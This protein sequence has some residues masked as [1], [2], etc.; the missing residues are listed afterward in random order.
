MTK[1][2]AYTTEELRETLLN[3][4]HVLVDYW[5]ELPD[6]TPKE[7]LSGL[8]HSTLVALDGGS[9]V[10]P[11]FDLLVNPRPDDK[12]YH[13]A[14][15]ENWYENGTTVHDDKCPQLHEQWHRKGHND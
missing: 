11:M 6:K 4:L 7:R 2:R 5:A 9:M 14:K 1:P 8:M 15:G 3:H 12:K 13:Q 10:L